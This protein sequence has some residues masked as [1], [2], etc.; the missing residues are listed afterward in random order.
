MIMF[1]ACSC[2]FSQQTFFLMIN[3][4][5]APQVR[6]L[7]DQKVNELRHRNNG[8][9]LQNHRKEQPFFFRTNF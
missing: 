2:F 3:N 6:W 7:L 5:V 8:P 1:I 4:F 9:L